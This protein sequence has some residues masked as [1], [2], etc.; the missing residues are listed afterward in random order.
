MKKFYLII[1]LLN[2]QLFA[3]L[4][5]YDFGTGTGTFSTA[6]TGSDIFLPTAPTGTARVYIGSTGG[7]FDLSNP[8]IVGFGTDTELQGFAASGNGDNLINKFSIYNIPSA[9]ALFSLRFSFRLDGG[10]NG[11]E[12]LLLIGKNGGFFNNGNVFFN[13]AFFCAVKFQFSATSAINSSVNLTGTSWNPVSWGINKG[14]NHVFEV[15]ANNTNSTT[16]NYTYGTSQNVGP[17]SYDIWLDGNKVIDDQSRSGL[18]ADLIIDSF[19]FVGR[20]S[21]GNA[22]TIYLDDFF[23]ST[24]LE[25]GPLPVELSSFTS[26]IIGN[27]VNLKWE[28]ATE[29]KNYGFEV[30]RKVGIEQSSVGNY[31][32][33]GFIN[34]NGNSNSPKY[35]SFEDKNVVNGKYS[36]RLKQIDTD[37]KYEY[38]KTIEVDLGTPKEYSLLQNYPNPFNPVSTI[39]YSVPS[40]G[41]V[42]LKVYDC[43]GKEVTTLVNEKKDAGKY[44]VNFNGK[45]LG[46]GIYF[47][48]LQT[49]YSIL[50]RK[51]ILLK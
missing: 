31:E 11:S 15:F 32:K 45:G 12:W 38:S 29:V 36:Y 16:A 37:G 42:S 48:T 41:F 19:A 4:Q 39:E 50:Y 30:E 20:L 9:S 25:N 34:G 13:N 10:E 7:Q 35:Y 27:T 47:Y 18:A 28:T 6:S 46:S 21:S 1:L 33:I 40:A 51:M 23:Y 22:A 17:Y 44:T 3:Q 26:S 49:D 24:S 8:G 43:L 2:I 5:S 14:E